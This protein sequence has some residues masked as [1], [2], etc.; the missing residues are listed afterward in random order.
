[1]LGNLLAKWFPRKPK[2][3]VIY[4][5][6]F[7][8]PLSVSSLPEGAVNLRRAIIIALAKHGK[9]HLSLKGYGRYTHSFLKA[10]IGG[11]ITTGA[12][13]IEELTAIFTWEHPEL[14]SFDGLIA[15]IL[16]EAHNSLHPNN[17]LFSL[18]GY[19]LN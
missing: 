18:S 9:V 17:Q 12:F 3:H 4:A 2:P 11:L 10:S 14:S 7:V 19:A 15:C 13:T 6:D 1:M 16:L 5:Y 8:S